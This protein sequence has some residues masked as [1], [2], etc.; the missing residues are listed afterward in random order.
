M[1]S[2]KTRESRALSHQKP[3]FA[4]GHDAAMAHVRDT[5]RTR[6]RITVKRQVVV[7]VVVVV[8][9]KGE[10][11]KDVVLRYVAAAVALPVRS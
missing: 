9:V 11:S 5:S 6:L 4:C 8:A 10:A 3:K 2:A 7:V 1:N